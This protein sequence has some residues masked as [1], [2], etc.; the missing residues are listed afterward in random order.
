M[1]VIISGYGKMGQLIEKHAVENG[2]SVAAVID[3]RLSGSSKTGAPVYHTLAELP[4]A[5]RGVVID[6][7]RPAAA[8][9]NIAA[10][11]ERGLAIVVGTTGWYD[12]LAEARALVERHKTALLYAPNFALGVNLFYKI[13]EFAAALIDRFD[14]YDAGGFEAHHNKKADSP[15]GTAKIIAERMLKVMTRKTKAV[16][17]K[18]DRPPAADE[19]HFASMRIGNI[20]GTHSVFFDSAA[21]TI[22]ITHTS[23]SRE[24]LVSGALAAALWLDGRVAAGTSGVFTLEDVLSC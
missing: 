4:A 24:G 20:A 15:S 9:E 10:A 5:E 18:L 17:D 22:E 6:F 12:K 11:A 1:R 2:Q 16:Y 21:D 23:R 3:P 13:V 19:L 7:T 14:D 8:L